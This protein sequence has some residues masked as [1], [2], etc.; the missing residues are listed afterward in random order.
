MRR[1]FILLALTGSMFAACPDVANSAGYV[2]RAATGTGTGAD[3]TNAFTQLPATLS[4]GCTYY[5]AA[6]TYSGYVF[7]TAASGTTLITIKAPTVASHGTATGWLD[8]FQGQAVFNTAVS[9]DIFLF[10]TGFWVIDGQY[11][12]T[13][14]ISGYGFKLNNSSGVATNACVELEAANITIRYT[15]C[16]GSQVAHVNNTTWQSAVCGA[17]HQ[18]DEGVQNFGSGNNFLLEFSYFHDVAEAMFKWATTGPATFQFDAFSK[19]WSGRS[20]GVHSEMWAVRNSIGNLTIRYNKIF[21]HRGT[22]TLVDAGG[23]NWP[24][25]NANG[26]LY[27]YGNTLYLTGTPYPVCDLNGIIHPQ[28]SGWTGDIYIV[29][30]TIADYNGVGCVDG[31]GS[32]T[33]ASNEIEAIPVFAQNV[34]VRNNLWFNNSNDGDNFANPSFSSQTGYPSIRSVDHNEVSGSET[35]SL[36]ASEPSRNFRLTRHTAA[37]GTP[38][39]TSGTFWNGSAMVANTFNVDMDGTTRTT[40]DLGAFELAGATTFSI[41]GTVSPATGS[42]APSPLT[43]TLSGGASASQSTASYNFTGL[44]GGLNYTVTPSATSYTFSP[45]SATFNSLAANQTQNFTATGTPTASL[46]T[47]AAFPNQNIGTTSIAR[48][49]SL[50]NTGTGQLTGISISITGTNAADFSL[51]STTCGATLNAN[52]SCTNSITFTPSAAGTRSATL[53]AVDSVGTQTVPLSGV[54][55]QAPVPTCVPGGGNFKT[56]RIVTCSNAVPLATMC[57]NIGTPPTTNGAGTCTSGT[58][59]TGPFQIT[60]TGGLFVTGTQ[61]GNT[62]STVSYAFAISPAWSSGWMLNKVESGATTWGFGVARNGCGPPTFRCST[63]SVAVA[64]TPPLPFSGSA[65]V[66]TTGYAYASPADFFYPVGGKGNCFTRL[67]DGTTQA[68]GRSFGSSWSGGASNNM[69]DINGEFRGATDGNNFLFY[70]THKD[71]N[72]CLQIDSPMADST[73]G[74]SSSGGFSFSRVTAARAYKVNGR[75]SLKTGLYQ[76]DLAY[77]GGA[78]VVTATKIF[79]YSN[80]PGMDGTLIAT[81]GAGNLN[82]DSADNVFSTS[83]NFLAGGQDHAHWILAWRKS[84]GACTTFYS[85]TVQNTENPANGN[86]WTWCVGNCS[87]HGSNPAPIALNTTCDMT[88]AFGVHDTQGF[89]SGNYIDISG[90]CD[91]TKSA[92]ETS[93]QFGTNQITTCNNAL[94]NCGGHG[95]DGYHKMR[96]NNNGW[97]IRDES[98]FTTFTTYAA[99]N[100]L[101]MDHHGSTN[102]IGPAA[103]SNPSVWETQPTT[104]AASCTVAQ[105]YACELVAFRLDATIARF[106]PTFHILDPAGDLG[107]ILSLDQ[108]GKCIVYQSNWNQTLGTDSTGAI[109]RDLFS[110]CNLQ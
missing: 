103:D 55:F 93:W 21:D 109:R 88:G 73:L 4:R 97:T 31:G 10:N 23:N 72:G 51:V 78:V 15:E 92:N 85:G 66:N 110:V 91:P 84:D 39:A 33:N 32:G 108:D 45:T 30:N 101:G 65:A 20:S 79:D 70:H 16:E 94:F 2:R 75:D 14:W 67:T 62:D 105:P 34:I 104:A 42:A 7:N 95:T 50:S 71:A 69:A 89:H 100:P 96:G 80:C 64:T 40:W 82:V 22:G 83:L 107:P 59:Y 8:T 43:V 35:A 5:V 87:Q 81:A 60:S 98:D 3:W 12:G 6:G 106:S 47:P 76:L 44:T 28:N 53:Q 24:T 29:N 18:C 9:A 46:Q 19:N 25:D 68:N 17:S 86:I 54:G 11:R 74:G 56:A 102:W 57:W 41:S 90:R 37:A 13:D 26:P 52:S 1:I 58:T 27:F 63:Q 77:T 38:I 61:S 48:N 49:P 99:G 36:F